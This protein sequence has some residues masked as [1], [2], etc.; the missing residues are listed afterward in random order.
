MIRNG[1]LCAHTTKEKKKKGAKGRK[2]TKAKPSEVSGGPGKGEAKPKE[3]PPH[4]NLD[5]FF[6]PSSSSPLFSVQ[7]S[8]LL[9][10]WK[11][12]HSIIDI[13]ILDHFCIQDLLL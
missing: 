11:I 8:S 1:D 2:S 10:C 12:D 13:S 7:D 3:E 4:V 9:Q 6:L 5:F